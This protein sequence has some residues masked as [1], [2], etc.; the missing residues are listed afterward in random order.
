M[1]TSTSPAA[2]FRRYLCRACGW[3]Y[4]EAKGDPDSGLPAGT[5]FEDIP[6]DWACPLCSVTKADF[7][8]I[9]ARPPAQQ[10]QTSASHRPA[11]STTSRWG[12][13]KAPASVVIVGGGHAG[14]S[15]VQALRALDATLPITLVSA[16]AADVYDKPLLSVAY[17]KSTL[18]PKPWRVGRTQVRKCNK[19]GKTQAYRY[20]SSAARLWCKS[21]PA[22][23][24]KPCC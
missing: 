19:H 7:E 6:D 24:A 15:M 4:D 5:R 1:D 9:Q 18:N 20:A 12:A 2:P 23:R 21:P 14:W 16:C 3:V 10:R 8:L 22:A 13:G 17:A 11:A